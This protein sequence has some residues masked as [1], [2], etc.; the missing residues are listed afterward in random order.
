M[1]MQQPRVDATLDHMGKQ[2]DTRL[3]G[4]RIG[5]GSAMNPPDIAGYADELKQEAAEQRQ[6]RMLKLKQERADLAMKL[7]ATTFDGRREQAESEIQSHPVAV[8]APAPATGQTPTPAAPLPVQH[9]EDDAF[10]PLPK[11]VSITGQGS[12]ENGHQNLRATLLVPYLGEISAKVGTVLPGKRRVVEIT[13]EGVL[14]SDPVHGNMPLGYGDSVALTPPPFGGAM[15]V[16]APTSTMS[17]PL[18]VPGH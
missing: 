4:L 9:A 17:V 14:V 8:P 3:D 6:I 13:P 7:W 12:L 5:D 15:G 10:Q 16:M 1:S 18:R 2:V 11:V